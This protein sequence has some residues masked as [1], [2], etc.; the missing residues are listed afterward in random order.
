MCSSDLTALSTGFTGLVL[1]A[2]LGSLVGVYYY[3]RPVMAVFGAEPD[4]A[5]YTVSP[6]LLA[7][8]VFMAAISVLLGV[9]P[10]LLAGLPL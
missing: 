7:T 8:L 6:V 2:V 1:I 3:F 4:G 5:G 10:G 9:Y